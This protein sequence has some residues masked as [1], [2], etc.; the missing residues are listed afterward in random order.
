MIIDLGK[1]KSFKSSL[2]TGRP[3][4][5]AARKEMNLDDLDKQDQLVVVKI[6]AGTSSIN[7]SFFLGLFFPS[8]KYLGLKK[9]EEK[10]SFAFEDEN[11]TVRTILRGHIEDALRNASNTLSKKNSFSVF[12]NRKKSNKSE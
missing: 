8:I 7:P 11:S 10:Y 1:Y 9:F 3:Q 5:E 12:L 4:G 2:F 6:P